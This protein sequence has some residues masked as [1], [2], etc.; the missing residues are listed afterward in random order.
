VLVGTYAV[1]VYVFS[2]RHRTFL[3]WTTLFARALEALDIAYRGLNPS[4]QPEPL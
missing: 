3:R 2:A 4:R 1:T